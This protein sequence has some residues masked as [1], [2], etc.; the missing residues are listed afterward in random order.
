MYQY[1]LLLVELK[2]KNGRIRVLKVRIRISEK[3]GS[4]TQLFWAEPVPLRKKT[5]LRNTGRD[6]SDSDHPLPKVG[7]AECAGVSPTS[8]QPGQVLLGQPLQ[9]TC[10]TRYTRTLV[11]AGTV[12]IR[13]ESTHK[14]VSSPI[15][16]TRIS[17]IYSNPHLIM[18][19]HTR[20]DPYT[21]LPC[22]HSNL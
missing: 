19:G 22:Q 14:I 18:R 5:R 8:R 4:G 6:T 21:T 9:L 11:V 20:S 12:I 17:Y 15:M 13:N 2:Q 7:V 16:R 3:P 1:S 10:S